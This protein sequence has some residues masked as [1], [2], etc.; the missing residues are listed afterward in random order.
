MFFDSLFPTDI[1]RSHNVLSED[2]LKELRSQITDERQTTPD[3]NYIPLRD[4]V[5]ELITE[6]LNVIQV[7]VP[8]LDMVSMWGNTMKPGECH[9]PHNHGNSY[10]SGV[11]YVTS[12]SDC[13]PIE[14][15]DPRVKAGACPDVK[16]YNLHNSTTWAYPSVENSLLIFPS[17]LQHWVP[18][19]E[20]Q[21]DRVSVSFNIMIRGKMGD[22]KG[23]TEATW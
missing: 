14:F 22:W 12:S 7:K 5:Y 13:P 21:Q 4:R 1:I 15:I 3:L 11:F 6:Y 9:R 20:S 19:N 16:E 8:D 17:W 10:F 23:L 2:Q 18:T